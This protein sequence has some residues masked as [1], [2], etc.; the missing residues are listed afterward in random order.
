MRRKYISAIVV[1]SLF[2]VSCA[3]RNVQTGGGEEP[4]VAT[5]QHAAIEILS[6]YE[7]TDKNIVLL[8]PYIANLYA[9]DILR[10]DPSAVN[11]LLVS[12][13][14]QWYLDHLNY[15]DKFGLTG[16]MYDY[17]VN[18]QYEEESR[19]DMD[20]VD[21]YAATFIM[22]VQR[23]LELTG[24]RS[25]IQANRSKLEDII[26]LVPYLQQDDRLTIALPGHKG[27]YLMDNCESLGGIS[28][29]IQLADSMGWTDIADYYRSKEPRLREAIESRFFNTAN[30]NYDWVIDGNVKTP[31][32]WTDFYPDAYAQLFPIF[33]QTV[34]DAAR[35]KH[36]WDTFHLF[37]GSV[38]DDIP[39]EQRVVY[40][41]AKEVYQSSTIT[42]AKN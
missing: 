7:D 34:D 30:N 32:T 23:Y 3:R 25:L 39:V 27:K 19:E 13:Y 9:L 18:R 40:E 33:Y 11:L 37:H 4:P 17:N 36:I 41:W 12:D 35:V 38:L 31:S 10:L 20:S 22:L 16:S 21:S 26:Y 8:I 15:P 28:A 24:D 29:F 14:I 6:R 5:W 2:I 42:P 1:I